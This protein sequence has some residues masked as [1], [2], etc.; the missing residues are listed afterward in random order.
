MKNPAY[1]CLV[2]GWHLRI[3]TP[4]NPEHFQWLPI[5]ALRPTSPSASNAREPV[6]VY[7]TCL[8]H[9]FFLLLRRQILGDSFMPI[10]TFT[11]YLFC[12]QWTNPLLS[13]SFIYLFPYRLHWILF[14]NCTLLCLKL[15]SLYLCVQLFSL[16]RF[17]T[18]VPVF[19]CC[20]CLFAQQTCACFCLVPVALFWGI[21]S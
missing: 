1:A 17:G 18:V 16:W 15:F 19:S 6:P 9:R 4:L 21:L 10:F 2:H 20:R 13:L 12:A 5:S 3:N 7:R 11:N 14:R 8:F